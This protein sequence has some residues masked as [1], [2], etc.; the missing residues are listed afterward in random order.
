MIRQ[1]LHVLDPSAAAA[2]RRLLVLLVLGAVLQGVAFV[3]L[4]PVLRS[5]FGSDP[6][7]A[8]PW[9]AGLAVVAAAYGACH[10]RSQLIGYDVATGL[11]R[12]LHGALGARVARLPLGWFTTGRTGRLAQLAS[13]N[14]TEVMGAPA[15]LFRPVVTALVTPAV[16]VVAMAVLQWRLAVA[17][18]LVVPVGAWAFRLTGRLVAGTEHALDAAGVEASSRLVEFAQN[19]PVL[20]AFRRTGQGHHLLDDALLAQRDAA[21]EMLVRVAPGFAGFVV[22]VQ[23]GFTL[24]LV[25]GTALALGATVGVAELVT[26]LV[27]AVRFVEPVMVAADLSGAIRAARN[28]LDR[29]EEVLAT[30]TLPETSGTTDM[31]VRPR[32]TAQV[33]LDGVTFGL[34]AGPTGLAR[35]VATGARTHDDGPGGSVRQRQDHGHQAHRPLLGRR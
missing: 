33:E 4:V 9:L 10:W 11:A 25:V 31:T 30:P 5:L 15:Q 7:T 23:A 27:L 21:R 18:A 6:A 1:L 29:I 32:T 35:G 2:L 34:R 12:A 26:L 28:S 16:V 13:T 22:V 14:V 3:L 24:V 8:W 20:R 17:V 19:Q